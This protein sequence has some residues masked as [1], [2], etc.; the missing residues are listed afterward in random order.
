LS[1]RGSQFQSGLGVHFS[2]DEFS[3]AYDRGVFGPEPELRRLDS[4]RPSLRDPMCEG[5]DPVY[6]IVMDVGRKEHYDQLHQRMLLFGVVAYAAGRLGA[7]PVRSQGHVH[8]IAP[9]CGWSTP[10]LFE[11]WQGLAIVYM[12]ETTGD[13]PG[14]CIAVTAGPGDKVVVPPGWAHCVISADPAMP[15]VF[16]A[17]CDRQYGFSYDDI[18]SHGGLAW[19]PLLGEDLCIRWERNPRYRPSNLV[20]RQARAYPELGLNSHLPIYPQFADDPDSV[21]WVSDP[22]RV[23]SLWS[24]FEP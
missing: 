21:Q 14:R 15:L 22:A 6:S 9:H 12:Q 8:K 1:S 16:G 17:W 11:V 18:R 10:E 3:F 4:I 13:D 23:E 19:F 5:A 20:V 2:S 7:E 24:K